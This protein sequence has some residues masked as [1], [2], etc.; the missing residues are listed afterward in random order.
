MLKL[1]LDENY[2]TELAKQLQRRGIDAITAREA[3]N[4]GS[5]MK[6]ILILLPCKNVS[7]CPLTRTM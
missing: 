2:L 5:P 6:L 1:Y 3:G 4:L 7:F